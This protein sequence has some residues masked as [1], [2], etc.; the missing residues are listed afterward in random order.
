MNVWAIL[1]NTARLHLILPGFDMPLKV[2]ENTAKNQYGAYALGA[3]RAEQR[4]DYSDAE[5]LWLKAASSPCSSSH[6]R[7]AQNRAEF[8]A[9]AHLKGWKPLSECQTI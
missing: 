5:K 6:R 4:G 1:T 2:N 9:N 8:C 3:S 7:W